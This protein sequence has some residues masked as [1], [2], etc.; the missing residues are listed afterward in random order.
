MGK[1]CHSWKTSVNEK[2]FSYK[3]DGKISQ[4]QLC[5]LQEF[6]GNDSPKQDQKNFQFF[7]RICPAEKP[8]VQ[9][10][11]KNFELWKFFNRISRVRNMGILPIRVFSTPGGFP[12][13][14]TRGP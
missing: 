11:L 3:K 1:E 2:I 7:G 4:K 13:H 12:R 10:P 8:K 9:N 5:L 6:G 14:Q